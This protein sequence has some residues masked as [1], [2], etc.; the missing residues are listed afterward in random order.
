MKGEGEVILGFRPEGGRIT[1][2]GNMSAA[3]YATELYGGY[4]MLHLSIGDI[5]FHIRGERG[6]DYPIGATVR[7]DVDP[8]MVRLFD[9]Q[10]EAAITREVPEWPM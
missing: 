4:T 8:E 9:P 2:T 10:T 7:F 1:D 6:I 3:V 5:V